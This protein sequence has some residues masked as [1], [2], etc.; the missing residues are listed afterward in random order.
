MFEK[1]ENLFERFVVATETIAV[2]MEKAASPAAVVEN[3]AGSSEYIRRIFEPLKEAAGNK[4]TAK[5]IGAIGQVDYEVMDLKVLQQMCDERGIERQPRQKAATLAGYLRDWNAANPDGQVKTEATEPATNQQPQDD[6]FSNDQPQ[7]DP[8]GGGEAVQEQPKLNE[9]DVLA[10][11]QKHAAK[12]GKEGVVALL[13]RHGNV[14]KLKELKPEDY[15][16]VV[17]AAEFDLNP[18]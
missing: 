17:N 13:M 10:V 3:S 18:K 15:R 8:F 1:F 6:P 2:C 7:E 11:L 9:K 16:A 4:I 14:G 5:D 12:F